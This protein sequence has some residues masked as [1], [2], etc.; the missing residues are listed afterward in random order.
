MNLPVL[1]KYIIL[2]TLF[3]L[4]FANT[5]SPINSS[6]S[7][8]PT[9]ASTITDAVRITLAQ[10]TTTIFENTSKVYSRG[11]IEHGVGIV[12]W[13]ILGVFVIAAV[14]GGWLLWKSFRDL[15]SERRLMNQEWYENEEI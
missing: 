14:V 2:T 11:E 8:T 3:S 10:R 5:S 13:C 1:T 12:G 4:S 6:R 15:A 7:P 9:Q